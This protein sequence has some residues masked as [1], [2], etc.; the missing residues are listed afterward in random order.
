MSSSS[1][2]SSVP[3]FDQ[4]HQDISDYYSKSIQQ[5]SDLK[6][7]AC[8]CKVP[9]HPHHSS[10]L[11]QFSPDVL[12]K[13]YG[14]GS[15]IPECLSGQV[16][17]DLGCGTGRDVFLCSVLAG[18]SGR[19]IGVDMTDD[20]LLIASASTAHHFQVFPNSAPIE[21]HKGFIENLSSVGIADNSID[22]VIS[23]CVINL[24]SD[25]QAV[26][27]EIFRVLRENGEVCISDIFTDRP[28]PQA[29]RDDKT[30]VGECIGNAIDVRTF[31]KLMETAGFDDIWPIEVSHFTGDGMAPGL[32]DPETVFFKITFSAFKFADRVCYW[33]GDVAT[34]RGGI[35]DCEE[36]F[37][38]DLNHRF[39]KGVAVPVCSKLAAVLA[40]R[41]REVIELVKVEEIQ[42]KPITRTFLET[43]FAECEKV[44]PMKAPAC[45]CCCCEGGC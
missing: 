36:R 45:C 3:L 2:E 29:A 30:L 27:S 42:E 14:C 38:F 26:F 19:S 6:F 10:I 7:Q 33:R 24:V 37:D 15:P 28:L 8:I 5:T 20:Q 23:N 41:Y 4:T 31:V 18:S 44:V 11:S 25:K 1:L 12:S 13:Y 9:R 34:Y 39:E 40:G 17:L 16:I 43:V 35:P 21:F 22:I 32:I